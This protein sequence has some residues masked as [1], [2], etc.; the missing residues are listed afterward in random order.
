MTEA[1]A[2]QPSEPPAPATVADVMHPP[3]TTVEQGDHVAAA[4]YLM[5]HAGATALMVVDPKSSQPRG[6]ITEADIARVVADGKNVNDVRIH[7]L[8]TE[9]PTVIQ[10]STSIRN[11]ARIMTDGHFRHLPVVDGTGLIGMVD[12]SDV[13]A[14]LLGPDD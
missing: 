6:I 7:D 3:V 9:E 10:A 13:C 5:K 8:M 1:A 11:A 4:A 14:A 12:I 2:P